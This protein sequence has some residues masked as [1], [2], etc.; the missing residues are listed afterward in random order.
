MPRYCDVNSDKKITLNEWLACLRSQSSDMLQHTSVG[1]RETM[2]NLNLIYFR[3]LFLL[4]LDES[5]SS[6]PL[7]LTGSNPLEQY[8]KD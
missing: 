2:K 6:K 3:Q 1:K 5:D 8:L 7:K 4:H